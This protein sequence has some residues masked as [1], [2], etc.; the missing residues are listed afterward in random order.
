[1]ATAE[2]V[3]SRRRSPLVSV[4][5]GAASLLSAQPITWAASL[6]TTVF[7]P[8]YLNAH[9]LGQFAVVATIAGLAGSIL[10]LGMTTSLA[11]RVAARPEHVSADATGA[12]A[13]ILGLSIPSAIGLSVLG[14]LIGLSE[15]GDPVLMIALI[16]MVLSLVQAQL[17][18]ILVGQQRH[19]R[20]AWVNAACVATTSVVGVAVLAAGAGLAGFM[21]SGI[22]VWAIFAV[23]GW[24]AA[25][26]GFDRAGLA[27]SR[28]WQLAREG[29]PF[30]GWSLTTR[31]RGDLTIMLLTVFVGQQ[32][33]GWWGAAT[34]IV[35]IPI[36]IPGLITTP[37]LPALTQ[38]VND[39]AD[40][41]RTL[42]RSLVLLLLLTVPTCAMI[43]AL[44]PTMPGLLG[45]KADFEHS[46]PIMQ[47]LSLQIPLVAVGMVLGTSL[48]SLGEER[49][50]L[51]VNG[52]TTVVTGGLTVVAI[53]TFQ[54]WNQPGVV[55][56]AG[57]P[58]LGEVM[59]LGGA[60]LL[61]PRSTVDRATITASVRIALAGAGLGVVAFWLAP[62][63][64]IVAVLGGGAVYVAGLLGLRVV[65]PADLAMLQ[66]TAR[67]ILKR[68]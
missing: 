14:P 53:V 44:A 52:I 28:L 4:L 68:R 23:L 49:R 5:R 10:A 47:L 62:L 19:A 15:S 26:L 56:A 64:T 11:R 22:P 55:G 8:R 57:V 60:L 24:R 12:L 67:D 51:V 35:G 9:D 63:S 3:D 6:L 58:I 36:F 34:R 29:L 43:I 13:L 59:M 32:A 40:F 45:W 7:V 50:W 48:T 16:A 66:A 31:L 38:C 46:V 33:V 20:F 65:G 41:D 54:A 39:R 18:T 27:P 2:Q 61:L 42:R 30:M 37:L 1:V 17:L 25:G 21:A